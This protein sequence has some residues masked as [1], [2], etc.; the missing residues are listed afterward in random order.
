MFCGSTTPLLLAADGKPIAPQDATVAGP[1][2]SLRYP[3]GT[4]LTLEMNGAEVMAHFTSLPAEAK[5]LRMEMNLPLA[6]KEGGKWQTTQS[7]PQPFPGAFAGEQYVF[8]GNVEPVKFITPKGASFSLLM[9]HGWHQVQDLRKWNGA[10]FGYMTS[11][12]L[13]RSGPGE[14]YHSF[15]ILHAGI[16][17]KPA[18]P[19]VVLRPAATVPTGRLSLKLGNGGLEMDGGTLGK[20]TLEY[21]ELTGERQDQ[22]RKPIEKKITGNTA[23]LSYGD[24]ARMELVL[25]P[26]TGVLTLKPANLPGDV[27]TIRLPM[28]IDFNFAS[29]GSWKAGSVEQPFPPDKPAKPHLFQGTAS[30][31]VLKNFEGKTLGLDLPPYS[32]QQ[33]QDNREWGWKIFGWYAAV[34]YRPSEPLQVK[35]TMGGATGGAAKPLVDQFGQT[36]RMDYEGKLKS[37]AELKQ[38]VAG[39]AA[40]LAGLRPPERDTFGGLP[41]SKA[42]FGLKQTG[43]FHVEKAANRWLLVDPEGNAFFHLGVCGFVPNDDFT[44]IA[45]R[46]H[47]YEWIPPY[48]NGFKTAYRPEDGRNVVSFHLANQ[49]RKFGQPYDYGTYST[50]TIERMRKWGFNSAG[51]FGAG[52]AEARKKAQFPYVAHLPLSTWEGFPTLPGAHGAFDPFD[53]KI[54]EKCRQV[55]AARL[56][57]QAAD[58]LI[59]GYFLANEPLYEDLPRAIPALDGK[60]AC[61]RRLAQMLEEKYQN[62][63]AY[64]QAWETTFASFAEVTE[65]GLPVKTRAAAADIQAF[66]GLFLETYFQLVSETFRQ[67]DKNHLLIGNRFQASTINNEQLC[68][69]SGKYMDVI[70]F[71]YYTYHLDTDFLNR[72][73]GWTG[74]KP[75]ILSEFYYNSPK[76]SGLPGG[77]KDVASQR[78]RGLGYRN[79]VEQAAALGFIVGIEWFTLVDQSVTGRHFERLNGENGNTGLIAVSDRPWKTM[80][81]EMMKSNYDIYPV[82]FG[83]RAPFALDDPRF[84][85]TGKGT[86]TVKIYRTDGPMKINGLADGWPGVPA[87]VIPSSRLVQGTDAGGLE[88]SYKLCWDPT[89]LYLLIHVT[90]ATPRQ[91]QLKGELLGNAD[92][93]ELFIGFEQPDQPGPVRATDRQIL[94]SAGTAVGQNPWHLMRS[95]EQPPCELAVIPDVDGKGY[96]LEA[97]IPFQALGFEP[98]DGQQLVFDL[99]VDDSADGQYRLRQI[100][101]NGSARNP[102]DRTAWGR[103]VLGR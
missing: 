101:W 79:Y 25:Q 44:F 42:K 23:T 70:S 14:A 45:G 48:D 96:T 4:Q 91:N 95:T 49:M 58:P 41:G 81:A 82:W 80:L 38:D 8:K 62:I 32:F 74:D 11:C 93:V 103:A 61:K 47:V 9:P 55:F 102:C 98:K 68:R 40:Y 21:P 2:A 50:R 84:S 87:E 18:L 86:K 88:A 27:K 31:L 57:A 13:P 72:I 89:H 73:H 24:Q 22:N 69:L 78:E 36:T 39:E 1:K 97:A 33:L 17:A 52:Q 19:P 75:M 34:P 56:P 15:K 100:M 7:T 67:H 28:L 26:E 99:G 77:G 6:F 94:L 76:D 54:R 20:F 63:G 10:Q 16:V 35:I 30:S 46:E 83:E 51:A 64:N 65:R 66:T 29:G 43:F 60:H 71:N 12:D 53:E 5:G 85:A 59:I 90:D 92:A 37:E 3:N